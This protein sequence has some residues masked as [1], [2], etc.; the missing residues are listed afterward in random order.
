MNWEQIIIGAVLGCAQLSLGFGIRRPVLG[1]V[2]FL[3]QIGTAM[4]SPSPLY[5]FILL[6]I[7]SFAIFFFGGKEKN[8]SY[9]ITARTGPLTGQQNMLSLQHPEITFGRENCDFQFPPNAKGISR[10]HCR[11]FLKEGS[12]F[13]EDNDSSYGTYLMGPPRKLKPGVP[14]EI[15]PETEFCLSSGSNLFKIEQA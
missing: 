6:P 4:L 14:V 8:I 13:L 2:G 11:V 3:L 10:N 15:E 7:C 1:A 12:L 5:S 9:L